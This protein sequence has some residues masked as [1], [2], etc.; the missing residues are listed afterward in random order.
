M[1]PKKKL[2]EVCKFVRGPFGGHLKKSCFKENGN[3]VY[4]QQ[5]AIYN[6][7]SEIRYF[8]D[9]EKFEEMKRFALKAGDLIMSCSGT[10]GKVAIVPE[11]FKK[12]IINQALLK[13]T[14]NENLDVEYLQYWMKS[15]D[16]IESIKESTVGAAIKNV[17]SVKVLKEIKIPIPQLEEQKKIV[18]IL[19]E[20]LEHIDQVKTNIE[21]N[22]ENAKE[23][24]QSKLNSIFIQKGDGWEEKT[25]GEL[26]TLTS[27]K[28]IYKK[29][30]VSEGVPF[31]RS[32]E[33]KELAH[34][35][36][37]TL[38]LY[39][40]KE[41]Y[42]EI[43]TRFG[44]PQE[45]D[46]LLTAVGTIGEMY[47]VKKNEPEF[48]FKDGNIMW[49]KNFTTLNT[50]YLKYALLCFVEQL[51]AM[52]QGAA[53][54]AL[55]IEKLKKYSISVPSISE[56]EEI[57]QRLDELLNFQR[58]IDNNYKQK[59]IELEE[60]KKSILQKAFTGELTN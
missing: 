15:P 43:K 1:L 18:E 52:S 48:Y 14:T 25:L 4:E 22:I 54:S 47:V 58:R 55:T 53:Y 19:D 39:I 42:A 7:F 50:Y 2:G 46:I 12:G 10:M 33:V 32:K 37:I 5:H 20:I 21:K 44:I 9:D 36:D 16:F 8:I 35:K 51:K 31:Y 56:Q 29:E 3:A 30:Y 60:L 38:E 40:T 45:G 34:K 23:L 57:V 11:D 6:Q 17:A 13:L 59:L 26:G 41:R 24:F 49:L 27:S 28:R